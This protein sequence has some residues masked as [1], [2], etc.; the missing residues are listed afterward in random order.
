MTGFP[1]NP[2]L[3]DRKYLDWLRTQ[4]CV[5]CGLRGDDNETIDPMHIGTAGKGLKSSDD[6]A[7]P[8]SHRYHAA[9]HLKGEMSMF[10]NAAPD[11]LLR[12]ALRAYARE[13]YQKWLKEEP[14]K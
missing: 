11:G 8:V 4:P 1:K 9:G 14:P 7:L 2:P 6:E 3:R 5:I 10:R 12:A 13:M